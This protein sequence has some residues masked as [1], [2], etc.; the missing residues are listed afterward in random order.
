MAMYAYNAAGTSLGSTP[1]NAYDTA[2]RGVAANAEGNILWVVDANDNVF[3]YSSNGSLLGRWSDP[4]L[5]S[6][7]SIATDG[8]NI[9][10]LDSGTHTIDYFAGGASFTSGSHSPTSTFRLSTTAVPGGANGD[11]DPTGLVERNNTLWVSD[12]SSGTGKVF[13]YSTSGQLE[14]EWGLATADGDPVGI[15]VNPT[16]GNDI[17]TVDAGTHTVYDYSSGTTLTSGNHSASSTFRPGLAK[18]QSR[19]DCRPRTGWASLIAG[20]GRQPAEAGTRPAIGAAASCPDRRRRDDPRGRHGHDLDGSD[21]SIYSLTLAGTLILGDDVTTIR[22]HQS[23]HCFRSTVSGTL[24]CTGHRRRG[25]QHHGQR[26]RQRPRL[27]RRND[28]RQRPIDHCQLGHIRASPTY[29]TKK[30]TVPWAASST[31]LC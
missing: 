22:P 11:S 24:T 4:G 16:S 13:V 7:A 21:A 3:V 29:S 20:W 2:P 30:A 1:L 28:H 10:I 25:R 26:D 5:S 6:P 19:R 9:W 14:G 15:T 12:A 31:G 17:W 23:H 18:C 27:V 8:T